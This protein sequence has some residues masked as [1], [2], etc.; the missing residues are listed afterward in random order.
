MV[1]RSESVFGIVLTVVVGTLGK[2]ERRSRI[3]KR[4]KQK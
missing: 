4:R 1:S 2:S 3:A